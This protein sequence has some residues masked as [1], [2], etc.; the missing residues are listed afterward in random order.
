M[1]TFVKDLYRDL[2]DRR[3][4][5]PAVALLIGL[6]AVPVLL[7]TSSSST[8]PPAPAA[9][10]GR[11]TAAEP[12][13]LAEEVGIRNFRQRLEQF[14]TKNPFKQHF[15]LPEPTSS[16]L[17]GVPASGEVAGGSAAEAPSTSA[18]SSSTDTGAVSISGS[19]TTTTPDSS[20][21]TNTVTRITRLVTRKVDVKV[22]PTGNLE[23][24]DDV[25]QLD[26]LPDQST[27][28]VAFLG[29]SDD[30]KR[31]AF[32][33]STDVSAVGGDGSCVPDPG[34]CQFIT[35]KPG[36]VARL[37]YAPDGL[38]YKLKLARIH[39]VKVSD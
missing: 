37:D 13:V 15:R 26:L 10:S 7:S 25:G 9:A 18:T 35:M 6:I 31:A 22:G 2:R 14:K 5:L 11:A 3:L 16:A 8:P 23:R 4:L 21:P 34:N 28:V 32:L 33:V 20:P 30:G 12:A 36:Q 39:E 17:E 19:S 29:V 27:P 24:L 38:T 1:P